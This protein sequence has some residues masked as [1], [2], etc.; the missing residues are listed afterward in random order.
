MVKR[1]T[2]QK[3]IK[4][5]TGFLSLL[6]PLTLLSKVTTVWTEYCISLQEKKSLP[7]LKQIGTDE[8]TPLTPDIFAEWCILELLLSNTEH[9]HF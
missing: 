8:I 9:S 1:K 2:T 3:N 7:T 6:L 5:N 4:R